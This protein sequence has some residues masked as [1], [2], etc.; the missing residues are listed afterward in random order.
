MGSLVTASELSVPALELPRNLVG[1]IIL[2]A[3]HMELRER[4]CSLVCFLEARTVAAFT[5]SG[6]ALQVQLFTWDADSCRVRTGAATQLVFK[7]GSDA[8]F[9]L[10]DED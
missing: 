7:L 1:R 5:R 6:D 10:P 3:R 8:V 9:E 4:S 2:Q